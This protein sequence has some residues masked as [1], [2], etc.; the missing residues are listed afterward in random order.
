VPLS[1][2]RRHHHHEEHVERRSV[3][4]NIG[5]IKEKSGT[6]PADR[7]RDLGKVPG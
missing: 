5:K 7:N 6:F 4:S 2:L 1:A 3:P